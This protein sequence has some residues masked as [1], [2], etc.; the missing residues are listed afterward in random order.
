MAHGSIVIIAEIFIDMWGGLALCHISW[1]F[2]SPVFFPPYTQ[3]LL[4]FVSFS[5]S[6]QV[7][8]S[9]SLFSPCQSFS[10][11]RQSG[12]SGGNKKLSNVLATKPLWLVLL[13]L[14][15]LLIST[16]MHVHFVTVLTFIHRWVPY[17]TIQTLRQHSIT[18]SPQQFSLSLHSYSFCP[19]QPYSH[20][21]GFAAAH[22]SLFY[23]WPM[24]QGA[25]CVSN[26][27]MGVILAD[28][29]YWAC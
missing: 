11:V 24:F 20:A 26:Q 10:Q 8:P 7:S 14:T 21:G 18:F 19:S 6:F 28:L 5:L 2:K 22:W 1:R 3:S 27:D 9:F 15:I 29:M 12:G 25:L 23:C 17:S 16:H 13:Q 4:L